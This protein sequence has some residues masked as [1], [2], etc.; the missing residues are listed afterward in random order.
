MCMHSSHYI[1][2]TVVHPLLGYVHKDL[3]LGSFIMMVLHL[4]CRVL[5]IL[6]S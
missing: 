4:Q 6:F 2:I 3:A 1:Y 5:T